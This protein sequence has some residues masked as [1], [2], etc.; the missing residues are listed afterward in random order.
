MWKSAGKMTF[1]KDIPEAKRIKD[2]LIQT[3]VWDSE[4]E[5]WKQFSQVITQ[6]FLIALFRTICF[7]PNT[8]EKHQIMLV[9]PHRTSVSIYYS[10]Y[11]NT[12]LEL[13]VVILYFLFV[14]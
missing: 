10:E 13:K 5:L 14:C 6:T 8:G 1:G 11:M 3:S 4:W 7:C 2:T 9:Y 12:L